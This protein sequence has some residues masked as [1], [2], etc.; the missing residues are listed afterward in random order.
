ML[1]S[2]MLTFYLKGRKGSPPKQIY[3]KPLKPGSGISQHLLSA[4]G[5]SF[6]ISELIMISP[7]CISLDNPAL[8]IVT[9]KVSV[10]SFTSPEK[11][12]TVIQSWF[13]FIEYF[14]V[15]FPIFEIVKNLFVESNP[16]RSE[17][18]AFKL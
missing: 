6:Q 18:P 11:G 10:L 16:K 14:N 5:F 17:R 1:L 12:K 9:H 2:K 7:F 4:E 3:F 8:F 13:V 15:A